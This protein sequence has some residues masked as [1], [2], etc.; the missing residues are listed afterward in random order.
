VLVAKGN[1]GIP[2][3]VEGAIRYN[4]TPELM[5]TY[6]CMALD[7]GARIIGGCCGTTP[8]HVK[9]MR[10]ALER[11]APGARPDTAAIESRLGTISTGAR[12]QLQGLMD[13][14]SGA[15]PGSTGRRGTGRRGGTRSEGA[16]E[17]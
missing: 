9:A 5:A 8:E 16:T 14:A 13:R 10:E 3:Y 12:A 17:A 11:H 15:A 7:A 1:C 6:A 2:Q 4:G